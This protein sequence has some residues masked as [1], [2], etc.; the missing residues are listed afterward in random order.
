MKQG[1]EL[2]DEEVESPENDLLGK[3]GHRRLRAT[4][5]SMTGCS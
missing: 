1:I 2:P 3:K 4:S 5:D